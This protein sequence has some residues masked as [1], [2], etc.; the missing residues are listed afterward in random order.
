M[1]EPFTGKGDISKGTGLELRK[2]KSSVVNMSS[3]RSILHIPVDMCLKSFVSGV[4]A[5]Q[6]IAAGRLIELLMGGY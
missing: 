5:V 4:E 2:I 6:V 1:K 3:L